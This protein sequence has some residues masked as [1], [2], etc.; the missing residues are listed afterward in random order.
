MIY[1]G[2]IAGLLFII[3]SVWRS[4]WAIFLLILSLP[5]YQVR[6]QILGLPTTSLEIM[7]LIIFLVSLVKNRFK[8]WR[9]KSGHWQWLI[10]LWLVAGLISV[11]VAS[12]YLGALGYW[13]AYFLEPILLLLV[14][15]DLL[16]KN[17]FSKNHIIF[18][19]GLSALVCTTWAIAQKWLGGGVMSTEVWGAPKV[20]RATGPFPQPNFLGLYIGPIALLCFGQFIQYFKSKKWLAIFYGIV[21]VLS[22]TAAILARSDGTMLGMIIGLI[23]L[24]LY[25]RKS[26]RATII[27]VIIVTL[28][29][30]LVPSTRHFMMER[31]AFQKLSG[32]LR[33]NIWQGAWAMIKDHPMLGV[34]LRNYQNLATQY[35]EFYYQPQTGQL[36]S[37]ETHHYPHNLFLA[38]WVELGLLGLL[39]FL[40]ILIKFF[41]QGH[42]TTKTNISTPLVTISIMAAL[43][44][45][46]AHGLVDTPYFKN[47]LSTLFWLIIVLL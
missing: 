16:A 9:I 46:V 43:I 25:W 41:I 24:G 34:G 12:D 42:K 29:I 26:R 38:I 28:I 36:I 14:I 4:D 47:D 20:W 7:I 33:L 2:L 15:L 5:A 45:I 6:W 31:L 39:V 11:V 17:R 1:F 3:L 40:A 10:L 44:A 23:F 19:L 35:Q 27:L 32:Q 22:L 21:F 30:F 37:T 8:G 13:R 18:A